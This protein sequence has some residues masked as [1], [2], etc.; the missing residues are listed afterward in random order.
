MK[1]AHA[2]SRPAA[3][4]SRRLAASARAALAAAALVAALFAAMAAVTPAEAQKRGFFGVSPVD[5]LSSADLATMG[6]ARVG[7]YRLQ[8][9]WR[10]IQHSEG[11]PY[12]WS[13]TDS[14]IADAARNGIQVLPFVYGTPGFVANNPRRAPLDSAAAKQ[15]WKSFLVAAAERYGPQGTFW[16][17]NPDLPPRPIRA[18]QIWNEQNSATY[19]KPKPSPKKYAGLVRISSRAIKSVDKGATIVLGGMFGTPGSKK[20]VYS[21]KFLNR[22]YRVKRIKRHFDAVALH[23]YSPNIR[24]IRAQVQRARNQMRKANHRKAPVWITELGWGSAGS[25]ASALIKTPAGQSKMLRRSFNLILNR[26]GKW[27]VRRLIW[28]TWVDPG[29]SSDP[30]GIVCTWCAS[31][32]LLDIDRNPKPSYNQFRNFTGAS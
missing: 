15:G 8:I 26:R 7:T 5:G 20:A 12:R 2:K 4:R 9:S 23:P 21:W 22:F 24:G 27:K 14:Q 32:G 6:D 30:V 1:Q 29:E 18:W 17:E 31:A 3:T 19:Y 10:G 25:G 16:S 11:G 28:F 13:E